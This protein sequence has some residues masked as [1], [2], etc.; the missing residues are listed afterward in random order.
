MAEAA[1]SQGNGFYKEGKY[2]KAKKCFHE[3]A[4]LDS[5]EPKYA[6]NLSAVLYE[7]GRYPAAI[8]AIRLAWQRLRGKYL[9]DKPSTP[10][11][12]DALAMKLATRFAKAQVNGVANKTISLHA[13]AEQ[14]E[15]TTILDSDMEKFSF[16]ERKE[17][18]PKVKELIIAWDLWQSLRTDCG[19]HSVEECK[20]AKND[21]ERTLRMLPIY[22]SPIDPVMEYFVFGHDPVKSLLDGPFD[23]ITDKYCLDTFQNAD[24]IDWSFV[25]GGSGDCRHVFGTLIHLANLSRRQG[26]NKIDAHM[27]LLDIYPTTLARFTIMLSL[28]Q[29]ILEEREK[30]NITKVVELHATLFYIYST[31]LMPDYCRQILIDTAG[32]LVHDLPSESSK[33]STILFVESNTLPAV[34]EVLQ[35]WSSPLPKSTKIFVEKLSN[36]D[37]L[38]RNLG[39][40]LAKLGSV[41]DT[42]EGLGDV[43]NLNLLFGNTSFSGEKPK[44]RVVDAYVDEMAEPDIYDRLKI[45]LPP[46]SL[47][48]RNPVLAQLSKSS[49]GA[50]DRIFAATMREIEELWHPNPTL[51]DLISTDH[52][53]LSDKSGYPN[54][55]GTEFDSIASFAEFSKLF[56]R[57]APPAFCSGKTSF[58]TMAQFFDLVTDAIDRLQDNLKFEVI[59]HDVFIGVQKLVAGELGPRPNKFPKTYTRMYLSNVPDYANGVLT[60]AVHLIPHVQTGGHAM[61]NCLL[62]T[63]TFAQIADFC[64]NYSLLTPDELP[65]VLGCQILNPDHDCFDDIVLEK[66]PLPRPLDKLASKKKLHT[67]LTHLLLCTLCSAK[68]KMPPARVDMPNNLNAFFHVLVHLHRVGF[69]SHWIGDFMQFV[70]SDTLVTD[71]K[72]YQGILPIPRAEIRNRFL[73]APRKVHLNVWKV[74]L[75][76]IFAMLKATLPFAVTL[77]ADYPSLND[78]ATYN[79]KVIPINLERHRNAFLW[80]PLM[81]PLMKAVGLMF[82][83]PH[84]KFNSDALASRVPRLLEGNRDV[85]DVE[86]QIILGPKSLDMAKSEISWRMSK[87][88]YEKMKSEKWVVAAY[89]TEL[90]AAIC[91]PLGADKWTE[92][93]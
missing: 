5:K 4:T 59:N 84:K 72:P 18:D 7:L 36:A 3:A 67:Y 26:K 9:D 30:N 11:P 54:I 49:T 27:T 83:R 78:I 17:Q 32:S 40:D 66:L 16:L 47:L 41:K 31:V 73:S 70:V 10:P 71:I 43:A 2:L 20:L 23:T 24:K 58:A 81:S 19:K 42:L 45:L 86:M 28:L 12:S 82:Y 38:F 6:S 77:P 91:E 29:Q 15:D 92:S 74:E 90:H 53:A 25:F 88:W 89:R 64:Y 65:R 60:T 62:N 39:M 37:D 44:G 13:P 87:A 52:P 21:A 50:S 46:K 85:Q 22:K 14:A 55:N 8:K 93:L 63:P 57:G 33:L 1:N 34:L 79:A 48:S 35:Y 68:S 51:F 75:Q 61:A 69:P 76:T 56:R 80:G